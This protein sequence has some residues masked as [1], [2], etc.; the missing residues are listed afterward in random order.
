MSSVI[1]KERI[2]KYRILAPHKVISDYKRYKKIR[3]ALIFLIVPLLIFFF[4]Y[5]FMDMSSMRTTFL[6]VSGLWSVLGF[7]FSARPI[8]L[9]IIFP[10]LINFISII[11]FPLL[12]LQDYIAFESENTEKSLRVDKE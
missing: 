8:F 10:V 9:R 4:V 5:Y 11:I 12:F 6:I 1:N 7:Y 2:S 3:V